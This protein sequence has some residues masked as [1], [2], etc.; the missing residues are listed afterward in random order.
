MGCPGDRAGAARIKLFSPSALLAR[1]SQRLTLLTGGPHDVPARQRTLRD[2]IAWSYNLLAPGEQMLFRR[3]AV[4]VGGF[5]LE[6]AHAVANADRDLGIDFLD[7]VTTLLDQNLVKSLDRRGGKRARHVRDDPRICDR[8]GWK[9]P[10]KWQK[11][12]APSCCITWPWPKQP[13]QQ[14]RGQVK[15]PH[16]R[17]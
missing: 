11:F 9:L 14:C 4:F 6:A 12:A 3:L 17:D 1:L 16:S 7:G 5:T 13:P 15:R 8:N 2:E 10:A